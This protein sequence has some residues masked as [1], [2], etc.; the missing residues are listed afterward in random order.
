[1]FILSVLLAIGDRC[2]DWWWG[3]QTE[4]IMIAGGFGTV[5]LPKIFSKPTGE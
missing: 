2:G 5:Y 4:K 1:M 3:P